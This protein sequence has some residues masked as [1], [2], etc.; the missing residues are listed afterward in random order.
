MQAPTQPKL[1][2]YALCS[3][4]HPA[5]VF[6][7]LFTSLSSAK[8]QASPA[9]NA[10]R[11]HTRSG[12]CLLVLSPR[13]MSCHES[14]ELLG[15]DVTRGQG[16]NRRSK[17]IK[18]KGSLPLHSGYLNA[19]HSF[20]VSITVRTR[21]NEPCARTLDLPLWVKSGV[22]FFFICLGEGSFG[23]V[24]APFPEEGI[25]DYLAQGSFIRVLT[26]FIIM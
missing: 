24:F 26:V 14:E 18:I 2:L 16:R 4:N 21:I 20:P 6:P 11:Y 23:V 8:T 9:A 7:N 5:A 12:R 13:R 15:P 3:S 25:S 17:K 22:F 10:A 19:C 1:W